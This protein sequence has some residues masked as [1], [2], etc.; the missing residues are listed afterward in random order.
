MGGPTWKVKNDILLL[1]YESEPQV[2]RVKEIAERL[3]VKVRA[4]SEHLADL[5]TE[6]CGKLVEERS[7][8]RGLWKLTDAGSNHIKR[9]LPLPEQEQEEELEALFLHGEI[10][11]GPGIQVEEF[12]EPLDF[13]T[14]NPAN[15]FALRV[16]GTSMVGYGILDGDIVIFRKVT[17]WLDVPEGK[18]V[19]VR[20]PE[21]IWTDEE[22]WLDQ[23]DRASTELEGVSQPLSNHATLKYFDARF[24]SYVRRGIEHRQAAPL[25]HGSS[26]TFRSLA[27]E[28]DGVMVHL[29]REYK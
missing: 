28:V 6:K 8:S 22:D 5:A 12:K 2:I 20:V 15:H 27:A 10:A 9:I 18:I 3:G 1:M 7:C 17:N 26:G 23:L 21:D 29:M 11:A 16:R 14:F 13:P 24:R 4:V 19:A 25:L